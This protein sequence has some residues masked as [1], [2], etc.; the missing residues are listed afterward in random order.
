MKD[1]TCK[2]PRLLEPNRT[3]DAVVEYEMHPDGLYAVCQL[4]SEHR[5]AC[6]PPT[7]EEGR[8]VLLLQDADY[9]PDDFYLSY[10][11][12][13]LDELD[14]ITEKVRLWSEHLDFK[15][16]TE[17]PV[18]NIE[19]Y[20][21]RYWAEKYFQSH[22]IV[23]RYHTA[24]KFGLSIQSLEE[25][26]DYLMKKGYPS[27]K[28]TAFDRKLFYHQD[29]VEYPYK[30]FPGT[31]YGGNYKNRDEMIKALWEELEK[32]GLQ[33]Q[34]NLY[35]NNDGEEILGEYVD[36]L[37]HESIAL[38]Y[39]TWINFANKPLYLLYDQVDNEVYKKYESKLRKF[40]N[41]DF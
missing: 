21:S 13:N 38:G 37:T 17:N 1:I 36:I 19:G 2:Y 29:F 26:V 27:G 6:K 10:W 3:C 40:T 41:G 8:L 25:T 12:V 39:S 32:T 20:L 28:I 16:C 14:F 23:L 24:I 33:V 15:R 30:L 11:G 22:K 7:K 18:I 4:N 31:Q 34:K 35:K 5:Q 9:L